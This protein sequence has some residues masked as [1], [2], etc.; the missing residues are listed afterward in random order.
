MWEVQDYAA[1]MLFTIK[2]LG[3]ASVCCSEINSSTNSIRT[4]SDLAQFEREKI[5]T[6][7]CLVTER[8]CESSC[9]TIYSGHFTAIINFIVAPP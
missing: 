5:N 7:L 4:K 8:F 9:R 2:D 3:E 1:R 6:G